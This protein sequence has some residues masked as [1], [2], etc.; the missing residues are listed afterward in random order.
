MDSQVDKEWEQLA[1]KAGLPK[2]S[3]KKASE[4]A[5]KTDKK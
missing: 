2:N 1:K 5:A 3:G 4:P